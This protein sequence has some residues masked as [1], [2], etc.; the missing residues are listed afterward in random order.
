MTQMFCFQCE[1]TCGGKGCTVQGACGKKADIANLQ[2]ELTSSLIELATCDKKSDKITKLLIDGLFT[3][4]TNVNFD[5]K[6]IKKL[7][8]NVRN[9]ID[10]NSQF[11]IS[12]VWD[13]NEDIRSLK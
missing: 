11:D 13:C 4:I 2:D 7:I 5:D 10:C 9:E 1:Q 3:T 12:S 8:E 6:S